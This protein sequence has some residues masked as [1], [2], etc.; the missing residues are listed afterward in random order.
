[1]GLK[2]LNLRASQAT[3]TRIL[4]YDVGL[5]DLGLLLDGVDSSFRLVPV[6]QMEDAIEV[7]ARELGDQ[8]WN[9]LAILCHGA[10]DW[11]WT[12]PD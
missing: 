7:I 4:A 1:M 2:A 5:P 10:A 9:E 6:N 11:Y 12:I 8:S 3:V